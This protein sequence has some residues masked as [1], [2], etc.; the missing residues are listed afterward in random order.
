ML[1]V[2][3]VVV[4]ALALPCATACL[5]AVAHRDCTAQVKAGGVQGVLQLQPPTFSDDITT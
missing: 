2:V 3:V 5:R 1:V 4:V